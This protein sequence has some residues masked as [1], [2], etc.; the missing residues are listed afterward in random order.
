MNK[1]SLLAMSIITACT[2]SGCAEDIQS[3]NVKTS[4]IYAEID[5]DGHPQS[6]TASVLVTLQAGGNDGSYLNMKGTE[7]QLQVIANGESKVMSQSGSNGFIN[8]HSSFKNIEGGTQFTVSFLRNGFQDAVDSVVL[9]PAPIELNYSID[10]ASTVQSRAEDFTITWDP[11]S[12]SGELMIEGKCIRTFKKTV[13]NG[14]IT[15]EANRLKHN[16]VSNQKICE[17]TIELRSENIGKLDPTFGEGGHIRASQ[18][19]RIRFLSGPATTL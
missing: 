9:L 18:T 10:S 4:G 6:H 14:S 12:V 11:A 3:D 13:A 7:D 16:T 2:V 19:A 8:Y 15:I 1:S 17:A 5:I